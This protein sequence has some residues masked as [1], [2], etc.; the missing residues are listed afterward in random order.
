[1]TIV[2]LKRT[3]MILS[4]L[5][6]DTNS[7][8]YQKRVDSFSDICDI[9]FV[10]I[11]RDIKIITERN[12]TVLRDIISLYK[13]KYFLVNSISDFPFSPTQISEVIMFILR[14]DCLFES[15][16]ESISWDKDNIESVYPK[17]FELFKSTKVSL[18]SL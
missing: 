4:Y 12:P 7:L 11:E 15:E 14:Q 5:N 6:A 18:S 16:E 9:F 1:M 13:P 3:K 2:S 8:Q 10:E 17:V